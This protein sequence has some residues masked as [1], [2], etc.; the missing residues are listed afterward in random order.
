MRSI[1]S[2]SSHNWRSKGPPKPDTNR[3]PNDTKDPKRAR[4]GAVS[5][6]KCLDTR[7]LRVR[8][9]ETQESKHTISHGVVEIRGRTGTCTKL[10]VGLLGM[11]RIGA[12]GITLRATANVLW[13][14]RWR[15]K[16][17]TRVGSGDGETH[18]RRGVHR[19]V[20]VHRVASASNGWDL[21]GRQTYGW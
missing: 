19:H 15:W 20:E 21:S 1:K 11:A 8:P 3:L 6:E 13:T 10:W 9:L 2:Q 7:P 18:G 17:W 16:T 4:D 5:V 12:T 14:W